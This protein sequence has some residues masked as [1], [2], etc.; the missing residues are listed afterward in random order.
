MIVNKDDLIDVLLNHFM[1]KVITLPNG[2]INNVK[3]AISACLRFVTR[4]AL[5]FNIDKKTLLKELDEE[6]EANL[7]DMDSIN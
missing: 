6:W 4:A 1:E 2:H 7:S 5:Q 3:T